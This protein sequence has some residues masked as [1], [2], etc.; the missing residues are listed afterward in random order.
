M[1]TCTVFSTQN[2]SN[3]QKSQIVDRLRLENS[4][5]VCLLFKNENEMS[6]HGNIETCQGKCFRLPFPY[7]RNNIYNHAFYIMLFIIPSLA[8]GSLHNVYAMGQF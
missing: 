4:I 5:K 3:Q 8:I 2:E 7:V 1:S 6:P